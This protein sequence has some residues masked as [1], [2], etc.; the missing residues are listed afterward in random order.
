MP[1]DEYQNKNESEFTLEKDSSRITVYSGSGKVITMPKGTYYRGFNKRF[2]KNFTTSCGWAKKQ[3][4]PFYNQDRFSRSF[5]SQFGY[6]IKTDKLDKSLEK[7]IKSLEGYINDIITPLVEEY[8]KGL[9][10]KEIDCIKTMVK[11]TAYKSIDKYKFTQGEIN[12]NKTLI[13]NRVM[14]T[15]FLREITG[16]KFISNNPI[17]LSSVVDKRGKL[18]LLKVFRR[19]AEPFGINLRVGGEDNIT[20]RIIRQEAMY[21]LESGK[22]THP[23]GI[24]FITQRLRKILNYPDLE[25][26][27]V[28]E[29]LPKES[30]ER[31]ELF[32]RPSL[33]LESVL[34]L[35]KLLDNTNTENLRVY[36]TE[37]GFYLL[38]RDLKEACGEDIYLPDLDNLLITPQHIISLM[39]NPTNKQN[40]S[41]VE[42]RHAHFDFKVGEMESILK[43]LREQCQKDSK[44]L[45]E[46]YGVLSG[47]YKLAE[48][49]FK[50][51]V[52]EGE[53]SKLSCLTKNWLTLTNLLGIE[54]GKPPKRWLPRTLSL[55]YKKAQKILSH[56]S[57]RYNQSPDNFFRVYGAKGGTL[58]LSKEL[59]VLYGVEVTPLEVGKLVSDSTFTSEVLNINDERFRTLWTPSPLPISLSYAEK[60]IGFI[61]EK[62]QSNIRTIARDYST[63]TLEKYIEA[64]FGEKVQE[65]VLESI[66]GDKTLL[67]VLMGSTKRKHQ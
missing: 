56:L 24:Y 6:I 7:K 51:G 36:G 5:R 46:K 13:E 12:G 39:S 52:F 23:N 42:W 38:G 55:N 53:M 48:D 63:G 58:V 65:Y 60:L 62:Y 9:D 30:V 41:R 33:S 11:T 28:Y 67:S 27:F 31:K 18:R 45:F 2:K 19:E 66:A 29:A 8:S 44:N 14:Y 40:V 1:N 49:L 34:A 57:M 17:D 20:K 25:P 16:G 43:F 35:G 22:Y 61:K 47:N 59:E 4:L 32:P 37:I 15:L 26:N 21:L 54:N 64:A 50:G 3:G 10:R